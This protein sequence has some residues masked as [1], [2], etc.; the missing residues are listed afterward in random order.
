[1]IGRWSVVAGLALLVAGCG[2]GIGTTPTGP[3]AQARQCFPDDT[4][5]TT[6]GTSAASAESCRSPDRAWLTTLGSGGGCGIYLTRVSTGRRVQMFRSPDACSAI[7]WARPHELL[8]RTDNGFYTLDPATRYPVTRPAAFAEFAVSP[9]RR[10]VAGDDATGAPEAPQTAVYLLSPDASTCVMVP[11]GAHRT[12]QVVGF[13]R[14]SKSLIVS[15]MPWNG[16]SSASGTT[17]LRQFRL[18]S[19]HTDCNGSELSG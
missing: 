2:G 12:D 14:D 19:F 11:L 1:L 18:S 3:A 10:W 5:V 15:S 16:T 4:A 9:D 13:T 6:P 8:F 17:Q 7:T